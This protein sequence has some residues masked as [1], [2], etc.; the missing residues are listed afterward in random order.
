MS[1]ILKT[2]LGGVKSVEHIINHSSHDFLSVAR[3][4]V[5]LLAHFSATAVSRI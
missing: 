5:L 1:T 2:Y 4:M 3:L